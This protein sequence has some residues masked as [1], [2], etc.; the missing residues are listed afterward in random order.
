MNAGLLVI[1]SRVGGVPYMIEH[2]KTGLLF[3]SGNADAL[4]QEML[5]A[6]GHPDKVS[7]IIMQAQDD[8][9]KYTWENVKEN[10]LNLYEQ[11]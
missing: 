1:S 9:Q 11:I 3:E 5:W 8:V 2:G 4:A 6:L 7:H 10:I